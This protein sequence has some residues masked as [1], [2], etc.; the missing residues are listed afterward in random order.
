MHNT[1]GLKASMGSLR[2]YIVSMLEYVQRWA[3]LLV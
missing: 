1:P 2:P 3:W